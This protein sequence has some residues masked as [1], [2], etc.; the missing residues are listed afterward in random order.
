[1]KN[2]FFLLA[3]LLC[4]RAYA[5]EKTGALKIFELE[6]GG[7]KRVYRVYAPLNLEKTKKYPLLVLLH[8][9]GGT[10]KGVPRLTRGGFEKLADR[11]GAI[12]AYPEAVDKNWND[13]RADKSR[14]SQRENIDDVAFLTAM[15]DEISLKYPVDPARVYASGIS[16]GSMMSYTLACRASDRFAAIAPVAGA[17]PENLAAACSPSRPVPVLIISGTK[18]KL[19][20]WEGGY[21]TGP[22]GKKK[23]G[24]TI[25]V[26]KSRDFWLERNSCDAAGKEASR[27]DADPDDGTAVERENY[28]ACAG[29]SAVE[30]IKIDGGGHT[31]PGGLQYLPELVIGKTSRELDAN[32][33]IWNFFMK[34][35]LPAEQE[36]R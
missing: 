13:Y 16:N 19:V 29:G 26:E 18:D 15:A 34:H 17:M 7:Y 22:F 33:E 24:R 20:H 35:S 14:K 8:G 9:G 30:F 27:L 23:L 32:T 3:V 28:R 10:G 36:K 31:W 6:A 4:G 5:G 25:S 12:L 2:Y 1:M 11:N 21:V